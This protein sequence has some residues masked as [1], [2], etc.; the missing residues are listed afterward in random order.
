MKRNH[1]KDYWSERIRTSTG[2]ENEYLGIVDI[3]IRNLHE[4][5]LSNIDD[6]GIRF[7]KKTLNEEFI[8]NEKIEE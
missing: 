1:N 8:K 7:C 6:I 5:F 2:D 3:R 4:E